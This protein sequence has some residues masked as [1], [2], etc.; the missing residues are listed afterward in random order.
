MGCCARKMPFPQQ[1]EPLLF[2]GGVGRPLPRLSRYGLLA[3]VA[4]LVVG[5]CVYAPAAWVATANTLDMLAT[6]EASAF[7]NEESQGSGSL[8]RIKVSCV[9]KHL[10]LDALFNFHSSQL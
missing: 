10:V 6:V 1:D 8:T 3:S 9:K 2:E 5:L 4:L 7:S